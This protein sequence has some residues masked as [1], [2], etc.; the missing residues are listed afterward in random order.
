MPLMRLNH[1]CN[2]N[3][4]LEYVDRKVF[5]VANVDVLPQDELT[6]DYRR[7]EEGITV[8]FTCRCGAHADPI[9]VGPT[10]TAT[11]AG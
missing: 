6:I 11:E 4:R 3:A 5:L 8:P 10:R 2:A 7:L 9:E 1:G